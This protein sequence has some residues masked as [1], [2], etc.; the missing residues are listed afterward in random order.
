L[1]HDRITRISHLG[2]NNIQVFRLVPFEIHLEE[3]IVFTNWWSLVRDRLF[4]KAEKH[5]LHKVTKLAI[6]SLQ[7]LVHVV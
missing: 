7:N 5:F 6:P 4:A 3:P 2:W 1:G